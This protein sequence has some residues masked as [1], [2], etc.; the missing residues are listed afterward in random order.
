MTER[1]SPSRKVPLRLVLVV[2]FILQTV[3]AVAVTAYFSWLYGQATVRELANDLSAE[4]GARI[5]QELEHHL[6]TAMMIN[7]VNVDASTLNLLD[8]TDA[9]AV[10][11]H[12]INQLQKFANVSTLYFVNQDST[13]IWLGWNA[14]RTALTLFKRDRVDQAPRAWLIQAGN[15]IPLPAEEAIALEP[16]LQFETTIPFQRSVWHDAHSAQPQREL[17]ISATQAMKDRQGRRGIWGVDISID[18]IKALLNTTEIGE[19]GQVFILRANGDL[20][21]SSSEPAPRP[22]TQPSLLRRLTGQTP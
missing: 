17:F 16:T 3:A 5:E 4:V 8:S 14:S 20:I 11:S 6:N 9:S 22:A 12:L 1:S 10:E 2:P 13:Y 19:A 18:Y 21:A 15:S 7:Q